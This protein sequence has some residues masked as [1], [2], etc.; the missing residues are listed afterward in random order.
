MHPGKG[1]ISATDPICQGQNGLSAF[2]ERRPLPAGLRSPLPGGFQSAD[3][4]LILPGNKPVWAL[5]LGAAGLPC[6]SVVGLGPSCCRE[7]RLGGSGSRTGSRHGPAAAAPGEQLISSSG[8]IP[9]WQ[10]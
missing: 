7:S 2:T 5:A 3:R 4:L 1:T 10:P 9:A 6:W 8:Y